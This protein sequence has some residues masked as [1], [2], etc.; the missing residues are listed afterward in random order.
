M[1]SFNIN[2]RKALERDLIAQ[3]ERALPCLDR[4]IGAA[5]AQAVATVPWL[6]HQES[7]ILD[8]LRTESWHPLRAAERI[9]NYWS[10]RR[11]LFG[12]DDRWLLPMTQNGSGALTQQEVEVLRTGFLVFTQERRNNNNNNNNN[13]EVEEDNT[14]VVC[15]SDRARLR[16]GQGQ[17]LQDGII[18]CKISFYLVSVTRK[19]SIQTV[20]LTTLHVINDGYVPL[21]SDSAKQL[22]QKFVKSMPFKAKKGVMGKAFDPQAWNAQ[23]EQT[24]QSQSRTLSQV[25]CS[26]QC[27]TGFS[28]RATLNALEEMGLDRSCIPIGMGG[29]FAYYRDF[30]AWVRQR[31]SVEDVMGAAPLRRNAQL[32]VVATSAGGGGGFKQAADKKEDEEAAAPVQAIMVGSDTA[33]RRGRSSCNSGAT[34][35]YAMG[36]DSCSSHSSNCTPQKLPSSSSS[37][38]LMQPLPGESPKDFQRRRQKS[39]ANRSY[40]RKRRQEAELQ[41][42]HDL[43]QTSNQALRK[44]NGHLERLLAQARYLVAEQQ[45]LQQ[46]LQLQP[47]NFSM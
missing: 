24:A 30:D 22:M 1:D 4:D 46:Q 35:G 40:H 33:S 25:F 6:V 29:D 47:N 36:G 13:E 10:L 11:E 32:A 17:I 41:Q 16:P 27:I 44:A 19:V 18:E 7:P 45:Q 20:G 28:V 42:R 26:T 15:I 9:A 14:P 5:Y 31:L 12:E 38:N 2:N 43:L 39:Y 34:A 23:L 3:V 8:F 21:Q 37:P